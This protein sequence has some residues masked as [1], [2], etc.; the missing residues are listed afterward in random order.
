MRVGVVITARIV[1]DVHVVNRGVVNVDVGDVAVAGMVPGVIRFAETQWEPA[2][3]N[4]DSKSKS[5]AHET[6]KSRSIDRAAIVRTW[7]PAPSAADISPATV[8]VRSKTPG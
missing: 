6:D 4:P 7:A 1:D 3:S 8:M 5:A 2:N